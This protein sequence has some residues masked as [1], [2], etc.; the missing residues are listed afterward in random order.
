VVW[1][2]KKDGLERDLEVPAGKPVVL[3]LLLEK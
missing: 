1:H 2:E 3:D